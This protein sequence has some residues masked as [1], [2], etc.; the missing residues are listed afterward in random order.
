MKIVRICAYTSILIILIFV[1]LKRIEIAYLKPI[2]AIWM[3]KFDKCVVLMTDT[4]DVGEGI[5]VVDALQNMKVKSSG[6]IYLDTARY[7]FISESA[8]EQVSDIKN[9]VRNSAKVCKWNGEGSIATALEY[10]KAHKM[11]VKATAVDMFGD[12]PE[13]P[14]FSKQK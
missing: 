5:D 6:I 3:Y 13:I 8:A 10:A 2:E 7:I 4:G 9:L 11:G 12:L 14:T 1:P